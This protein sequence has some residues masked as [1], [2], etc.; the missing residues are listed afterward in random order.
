[1]KIAGHNLWL[2]LAL[3]LIA[4]SPKASTVA[5]ADEYVVDCEGA[6]AGTGV[7]SDENHTKFI[8]AG[9]AGRVV[10]DACKSP[11]LTSPASGTKLD[12]LQ[13]PV[14]TFSAVPPTCALHRDRGTRF[15]CLDWKRTQP[16]WSSAVESALALVIRPAEAHCAAFTGENYF[17]RLT[18]AADNDPVYSAMLSVTSFTPD[19][20]VWKKALAGRQGQTLSLTIERAIFLR[21]D[22]LQGPY[23]QPRPYTLVVGP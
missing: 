16:R 17:L 1:M 19:A 5:G 12:P 21:G 4:C 15:G 3:A 9:S 20:A 18:R 11:L 10:A 14:I 23:V 6:D 13:P 22:I 8:E 7:T 2:S